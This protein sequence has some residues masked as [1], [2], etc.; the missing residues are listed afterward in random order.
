M[1][2]I[3]PTVSDVYTN[4]EV[5]K[6]KIDEVSQKLTSEATSLKNLQEQ[7]K[8]LESPPMIG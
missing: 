2:V 4:T 1:A 8:R 6:T 5:L 3:A 7:V